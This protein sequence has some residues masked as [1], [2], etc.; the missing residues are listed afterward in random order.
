[1]NWCDDTLRDAPFAAAVAGREFLF[2][3]SVQRPFDFVEKVF[4]QKQTEFV[5]VGNIFTF[6]ESVGAEFVR[7]RGRAFIVKN[8]P[9]AEF[10]FGED[11]WV[12]RN[13]VPIGKGIAG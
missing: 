4:R 8:V 7:R 2:E 10:V 11:C 3:E 6:I 13:F 5:S 12:Q 9:K 1:M